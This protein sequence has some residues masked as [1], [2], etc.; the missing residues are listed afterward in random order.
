MSV[1]DILGLALCGLG[2]LCMFAALLVS[3]DGTAAKVL[4]ATSAATFVP[5][6]LLALASVRRHLGPPR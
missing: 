1:S 2:V 5:G 6:A 3:L 4:M